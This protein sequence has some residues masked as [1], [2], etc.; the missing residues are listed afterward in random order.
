MWTA[1]ADGVSLAQQ[2]VLARAIEPGMPAQWF[3]VLRLLQVAPDQRMTMSELARS[4]SMS[5][6]GFTKLADRLAQDG[7]IDRRGVSG[8][9]RVVHAVLTER[10][11]LSAEESVRAYDEAVAALVLEAVTA[12]DIETLARIAARLK[13]AAE[14]VGQD[15]SDEP[16]AF[17]LQP[18]PPASPDRRGRGTGGSA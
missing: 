1:A 8:D 18:P 4:L 14:A 5:S 11:R 6:G 7:L 13:T 9:R 2:A 16:G 3:T 12:E 10:G 17:V 15:A